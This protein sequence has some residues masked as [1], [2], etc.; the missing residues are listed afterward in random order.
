VIPGSV[1]HEGFPSVL[2]PPMR[3]VSVNQ[4]SVCAPD[5]DDRQSIILEGNGST[6]GIEMAT[7]GAEGK[8]PAPDRII[9]MLHE[10]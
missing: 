3:S 10:C 4:I 9:S 8:G 1:F 2:L 5:P 7:A 6:Q